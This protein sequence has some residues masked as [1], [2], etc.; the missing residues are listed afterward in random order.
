[1]SNPKKSSSKAPTNDAAKTAAVHSEQSAAVTGDG[2]AAIPPS[3][4]VLGGTNTP[5]SESGDAAGTASAELVKPLEAAPTG[6]IVAEAATLTI[7]STSPEV[8]A[9]AS[10][11]NFEVS[12]GEAAEG[13]GENAGPIFSL[14]DVLVAAAVENVAQL[15]HFAD[16]GRRLANIARINGIDEA[17][18][19]ARLRVVEDASGADSFAEAMERTNDQ[20]I[21]VSSKRDGFRRAGL[22][23]SVAGK[24]FGVGELTVKQLAA[25]VDDPLITVEYL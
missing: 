25:L 14:D 13:T 16:V 10:G 11:T 12:Q 8:E 19:I 7:S 4:S 5:A 3:V 20:P 9:S 15:L 17:D 2:A 22:V 1:M 6:A 21:R 18:F 23:H 24:T